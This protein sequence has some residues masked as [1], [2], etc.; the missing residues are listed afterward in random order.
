MAQQ[1]PR[2]LD[3]DVAVAAARTRY[4]FE[5][6]PDRE[7]LAVDRALAIGGDE[8]DAVAHLDVHAAREEHRNENLARF[9]QR[10]LFAPFDDSPR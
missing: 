8:H 1:R 9:D 2:V 6:R 7:G 10:R 3:V 4:A 5:N